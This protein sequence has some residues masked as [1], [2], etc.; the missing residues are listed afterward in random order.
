MKKSIFII[1]GITGLVF[2]SFLFI[3]QIS[4]DKNEI[5]ELR[6]QHEVFLRNS[7]FS[8]SVKYLGNCRLTDVQAVTLNLSYCNLITD[9]S[10]KLLGDCYTLNIRSC[11][12]FYNIEPITLISC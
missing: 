8:E 10:V 4:N 5:S 9:K 3:N 1:F 7:P 6:K 12:F 11:R 2:L